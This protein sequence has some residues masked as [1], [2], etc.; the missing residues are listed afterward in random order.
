MRAAI[1]RRMSSGK[2]SSE[3]STAFA[4]LFDEYKSTSEG[5][6]G[7]DDIERLC[8][9]M[10]VEPQAMRSCSRACACVDDAGVRDGLHLAGGVDF[11]HGSTWLRQLSTSRDA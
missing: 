7:P 2:K 4:D 6:I 11:G 5:S 1:V 9:A 3:P 10:R 8:T